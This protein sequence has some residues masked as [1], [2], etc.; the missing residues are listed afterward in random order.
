LSSTRFEQPSVHPQED[1]YLQF[2]GIFS[3]IRKGSLVGVR[4]L[5]ST[6][7]W[8]KTCALC[9]FLLHIYYIILYYIILYYIIL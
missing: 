5:T 3:R 9:R 1:L 7:H 8:W 6:R 2:Y 4:I